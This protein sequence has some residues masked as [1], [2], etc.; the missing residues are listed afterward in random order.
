MPRKKK[1]S[2]DRDRPFKLMQLPSELRVIISD[3]FIADALVN[4]RNIDLA[5]VTTLL[6]SCR[7]IYLGAA[8]RIQQVLLDRGNQCALNSKR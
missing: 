4:I 5:E 8:P 6:I 2:L 7:E 3:Y 1:G